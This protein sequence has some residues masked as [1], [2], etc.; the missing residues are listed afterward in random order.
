MSG[1]R[2]H[3]YDPN[4]FEQPGAPL[5]PFNWVQWTGVALQTVAAVLITIDLLARIG[6]LPRLVEDMSP[7]PFALLVIGMVL[8]N[9]RRGPARQFDSEQMAKNRR[10][11]LI[12]VAICAAV[13]GAALVIDFSGA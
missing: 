3:S 10:T 5:K 11:L 2:Q 7:A 13:I 12:T 4:A 1:Y 6:W 8:I 9:S